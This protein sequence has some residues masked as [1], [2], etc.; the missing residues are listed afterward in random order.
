MRSC[1]R[2]AQQRGRWQAAFNLAHA[3]RGERESHSPTLTTD[4]KLAQQLADILHRE[5]KDGSLEENPLTLRIYLCLALGEF[6]VPEGLPVLIEAATTVR[7]EKESDVRRAALE[8]IARLAS[9]VG[10]DDS[11]FADNSQLEEVLL[12]AAADA[13][14]TVQSVA[15][16]SLGVIGTPR[17]IE[18]LQFML[19]DANPDVRY[20]A[21]ARL[22][23]QGR[24]SA[25]PVLVE[26]LDQQE[27]AG[28]DAE[29][30]PELRPFKRALITINALRAAGQLAERNSQANLGELE[31]AVKKLLGENPTPEI[32]IE[33]T[34]T[35]QR[36]EKRAAPAAA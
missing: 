27:T 13:D 25:V 18:K 30:K 8:G 2:W 32:R 24:E 29:Q 34:A 17:M 1:G 20:N 7:D 14:P 4:R 23:Q 3:L 15:A 19:A 31:A 11:H 10:A 36:L 26:M 5:I 21:A 22:A 35:L 28:V 12:D 16:V 9:N 6:R 33:A